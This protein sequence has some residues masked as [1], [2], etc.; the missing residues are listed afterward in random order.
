MAVSP[1]HFALIL[2][3]AGCGTD[4]GK[5]TAVE[6]VAV[7]PREAGAR[8]ARTAD[9]DLVDDQRCML[10]FPS[11]AYLAADA[12]SNTGL[13]VQVQSS[14]LPGEGDDASYLNIADGFSTV[15]PVSTMFSSGIDQAFLAG[16]L[17][18]DALENS[19]IRIINAQ[20]DSPQ[21]GEAVP[22]WAEVIEGGLEE[23]QVDLLIAYPL[24]PM[25]GNTEYAVIITDDLLDRDGQPQLADHATRVGLGL[26]APETSEEAA[27]AGHQAPLQQLLADLGQDPERV[28]RAWD[29]VTRSDENVS[30]RMLSMMDSAAGAMGA[31]EV[32]ITAFVTREHPDVEGIVL[33][34]LDGVPNYLTEERRLVLDDDGYPVQQGTRTT[35]FRVVLPAAGFEGEGERYR[36]TLY[37]HGTAGSVND[38]SFD[39]ETAAQGVAKVN[40]EFHGWT[41]EDLLFTFQDLLKLVKGS[42]QSTAQLMQAV[43]DGYALLKAME[44][45]L[46]EALAADTLA[47]EPNPRAGVLPI[48][49]QPGWVGGSLGGTMGAIV[50]A[51]YPEVE[52]AVL[53]VP[54]GA[55]SHFVAD[56]FMYESAMRGFLMDSYSSELEARFAMTLMQTSWDD[57]DGAA[58]SSR[59]RDEGVSFLL[60]QSMEDQIVPNQ[61]THTLAAALGAQMVGEAFRT[62]PTVDSAD[63]VRGG[64]GL[65]QYWVPAEEPLKIHGFAARDTPAAEAAMEQIL[66]FMIT[67]WAGESE[68]AL[69]SGCVESGACDFRDAW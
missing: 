55:W 58:W 51:A 23:G 34:E 38:D 7:T 3:L 14:S 54:A 50:A 42:E 48:T 9:C 53:N 8:Q 40:L 52:F 61:A 24:L 5:N 27:L 2:L 65:T 28:V 4:P 59:A 18:G 39:G 36:I 49:D 1:P 20:P 12:G 47:G 25:D 41:D 44:G 62:I 37:G 11:S 13:R 33:G 43:V 66:H 56:S 63:V 21:Y 6:D 31:V 22:L 15:S 29:F 16:H 60:Q 57:V 32:R 26:D 35:R 67:A 30:R 19:P 10:P 45:D 17:H 64:V 46:G 69:P 68:V